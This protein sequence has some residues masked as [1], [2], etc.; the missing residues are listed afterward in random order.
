MSKWVRPLGSLV[1]LGI[2][3]LATDW[4]RLAEVMRGMHPGPWLAAVTV[5]VLAQAA[6]SL[7]WRQLAAALGLRAGYLR[8]L[9]LYS[10]GMF[11]NLAL[12]TS[13][14][15]D[16]VRALH[17][18]R[19]SGVNGQAAAALLSVFAERLSGLVVLVALAVVA[20]LASPVPLEP[21]LAGAVAVVGGATGLG[22]ALLPAVA[23][24]GARAGARF[25]RV[26]EL[27]RLVGGRPGLLAEVTALSLVVQLASVAQ[28]WLVARALGLEVPVGYLAVVVPVATL[29]TLLPI[30]VNG[31][32]LRELALVVLLAPVGL[33]KAEAVS[34]GLLQLA[35]TVSA[36]LAGGLVYLADRRPALRGDSEQNDQRRAA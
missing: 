17:L 12:P 20:A 7:R 25:E 14:G 29:V 22:L 34:L 26:A 28:T 11:F 8:F 15:G 32:G 33:G 36:G 31:M 30:S 1:L 5:Y 23:L 4:A 2:L 21:W 19:A 10:V 13:V 3:G 18:P 9:A 24:L 35:V 16:V 27:L 6:S